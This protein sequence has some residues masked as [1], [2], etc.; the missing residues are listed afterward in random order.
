MIGRQDADKAYIGTIA[1]VNGLII[2]TVYPAGFDNMTAPLVRQLLVVDSD[3][4]ALDKPREDIQD[5]GYNAIAAI[6]RSERIAYCCRRGIVLTADANLLAFA[7]SNLAGRTIDWSY[8]KMQM[9]DTIETVLGK[10]AIG[11][12]TLTT[13]LHAMPFIW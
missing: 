2:S 6:R 8:D 7:D 3:R 4:I 11:I 12:D 10:I 9:I 13:D 1:T 5:S